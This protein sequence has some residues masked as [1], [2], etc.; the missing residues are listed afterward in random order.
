MPGVLGRGIK[1]EPSAALKILRRQSNRIACDA[2]VKMLLINIDEKPVLCMSTNV[3][4]SSG[5]SMFSHFVSGRKCFVFKAN[6]QIEIQE[7]KE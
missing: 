6:L 1:F 4:N 5:V 7:L 2:D 3:L